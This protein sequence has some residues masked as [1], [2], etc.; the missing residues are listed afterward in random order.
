MKESTAFMMRGELDV[1]TS[2]SEPLSAHGPLN[3]TSKYSL[4]AASTALVRVRV[5]VRVRARVKV[6]L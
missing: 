3:C 2:P 6:R 4:A 5:R 1:F